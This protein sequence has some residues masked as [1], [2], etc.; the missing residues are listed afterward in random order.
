MAEKNPKKPQTI[1]K[2][3]FCKKCAF[4]SG[5]KKDYEKH[6]MTKKH[7]NQHLAIKKAIQIVSTPYI[8]MSFSNFSL[9]KKSNG[10]T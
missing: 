4:S 1:R 5:N 7:Q 3:Y 10:P 6:L 9:K 2:K 8:S